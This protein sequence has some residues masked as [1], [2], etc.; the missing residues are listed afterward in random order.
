LTEAARRAFA[1]AYRRPLRT[2][3]A[4]PKVT[5]RQKI[6]DLI[7][8]LR[9]KGRISFTAEVVRQARSRL[10]VV[11]AFLAMLELVKQRLVIA[12]QERL[13]GDIQLEPAAPLDPEAEIASEFGE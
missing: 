2:V 4:P 1:I 12:R 6:R 5:I 11:V 13:F 3:V 10:E 9:R 7:G 8:A